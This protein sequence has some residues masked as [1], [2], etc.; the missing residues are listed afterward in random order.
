MLLSLISM[1]SRFFIASILVF[2]R[3][4]E[5]CLI[6]IS[7]QLPPHFYSV[8]PTDAFFIDG[9]MVSHSIKVKDDYI[10]IGFLADTFLIL[11]EHS[12]RFPLRM[13]R[14]AWVGSTI[15]LQRPEYF[16]LD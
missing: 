14:V 10:Q 15:L 6:L 1:F 8:T 5:T 13:L 7:A 9:L 3:R 4:N 16:G 12:R 11:A 2:A